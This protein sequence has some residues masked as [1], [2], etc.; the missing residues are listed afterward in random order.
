MLW[1]MLIDYFSQADDFNPPQPQQGNMALFMVMFLVCCI[2]VIV[3]KLVTADMGGTSYDTSANVNRTRGAQGLVHFLTGKGSNK[4]SLYEQGLA[5]SPTCDCGGLATPEHVVLEYHENEKIRR[6]LEECL[7]GKTVWTMLRNEKEFKQ[8][9]ILADKVSKEEKE[10]YVREMLVR[11]AIAN[12][13]AR[14]RDDHSGGDDSSGVSE[15]SEKRDGLPKSQCV[16]LKSGKMTQEDD[17]AHPKAIQLHTLG[18]KKE[19]GEDSGWASEIT[20]RRDGCKCSQ[21]EA[22]L[23]LLDMPRKSANM[24]TP[25]LPTCPQQ[26]TNRKL[27]HTNMRYFRQLTLNRGSEPTFAWRESG[28]PFRKNYPP[29]HLTEIRTLISPSSAVGLNTTSARLRAELQEEEER[30]AA[31]RQARHPRC[32]NA[33]CRNVLLPFLSGKR[34]TCAE[35][36]DQVCRPCAERRGD[37]WVCVGCAKKS[38]SLPLN[39]AWHEYQTL[40]QVAQQR[41]RSV[42][43]SF[44]WEFSHLNK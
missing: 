39:I 18:N 2:E 9:N 19:N 43:I 22:R 41:P 27:R 10:R 26:H 5:E 12:R 34:V 37:L 4:A 3:V 24:E 25:L 13:G 38:D 36:E 15:N 28:K 11:R 14:Q 32:A 20:G 40:P 8:L 17:R 29:V 16:A 42:Q 30:Q 1:P 23:K 33:Q 31:Q 7:T 44:S 6:E 21:Q 35:C